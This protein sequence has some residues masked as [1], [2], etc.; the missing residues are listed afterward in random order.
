[1]PST[2]AE[3]PTGGAADAQPTRF[4]DFGRDSASAEGGE[5]GE[6][7][8]GGTLLTVLVALG[9]NALIAVA[10]SVVALITGSA[11]MVAEAA[12][13]WADAGNEVFLLIAERRSD[14]PRDKNHPLGFGR[15]AYIWSMFAAFGL[16][17]AGSVVSIWHGI[18]SLQHPEEAADYGWAYAVLG[19]SFALEGVSWL[20]AYRQ[21]RTAA[22][23][24]GISGLRYVWSTPDPT[25]RAVFAEDSAAL[26]GLLIAGAGIGLHQLTGKAAYDAIGSILVGVL[27]GVVAVVLINRNR[28]FLN[29]QVV[30]PAQQDKVLRALLAH[31]EI[32]RVTYLFLEWVGPDTVFLIAAVDLT[33]DHPEH[34]LAVTLDRLGEELRGHEM[35]AEA[36]LTLAT[37]DRPSLLP[38]D[39]AAA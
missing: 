31:P 9:A 7:K 26:I 24:R 33:G 21:A 30:S 32:D 12:H 37:P 16:F 4:S 29:G 10:K 22:R 23:R 6:K 35:V 38:R 18:G 8:G 2:P 3:S 39:P 17:S 34:E 28:A 11:S 14:H 1:M 27:L 5:D 15:E 13:S 19:L 36:I 25:L 20:Q